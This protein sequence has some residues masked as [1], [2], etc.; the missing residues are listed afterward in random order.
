MLVSSGS[1]PK[2]EVA[3]P[4]LPLF[5]RVGMQIK[6]W[7][8]SFNQ[9]EEDNLPEM[10]EPQDW[11]NLGSWITPCSRAAY[12]F[13]SKLKLCTVWTS[14]L[15]KWFT[16]LPILC[17]PHSRDSQTLSRQWHSWQY[18]QLSKL[19]WKNKNNALAKR[20]KRKAPDGELIFAKHISDKGIV[21]RICKEPLKINN[22]KTKQAN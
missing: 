22:K 10:M 5:L 11:K 12:P 14:S 6:S 15:E 4:L 20:L 21:S 7:W 9:A 3:C 18:F 8:M 17:V 19:K 2:K 1:F 13:L 16:S